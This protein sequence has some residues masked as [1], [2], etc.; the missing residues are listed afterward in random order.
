MQP[1]GSNFANLAQGVN[2]KKLSHFKNQDIFQNLLKWCNFLEFMPCAEMVKS[3]IVVVIRNINTLKILS[4]LSIVQ[5]R[6]KLT[7]HYLK[8]LKL[9]LVS[10]GEIRYIM[11][12]T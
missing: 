3:L 6:P 1:L 4:S 8:V 9:V 7:W 10:L 2:L 12:I 5:P 11:K